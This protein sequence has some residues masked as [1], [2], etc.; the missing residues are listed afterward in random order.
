MAVV[1][2][3]GR[4][5][6]NVARNM[7]AEAKAPTDFGRSLEALNVQWR[8]ANGNFIRAD[9]LLVRVADKFKGMEDGAGKT[10][11][12]MKIFGE[13][14]GPRLVS[15]LNAGSDG[16]RQM[17]DE[18]KA[19]GI[20]FDLEAGQAAERFNDNMDRI[21]KAVGSFGTQVTTRILPALETLSKRMLEFATNSEIGK[22]AADAVAFV[23]KGLATVVT[24]TIGKLDQIAIV[25]K[26]TFQI[27]GAGARLNF[28]QAGNLFSQM[29]MELAASQKAAAETIKGIWGELAQAQLTQAAEFQEL[30]AAPIVRSTQAMTAAQREYNT[31]VSEGASIAASFRTPYEEM[32]VQ[33]DKLAELF[34]AGAIDADTLGKAN[35]KAAFSMANAYA[36]AAGDI[37][38]T[39][40]GV[41]SESKGFAI[42]QALINTAQGVTRTLAQYGAT[43]WGGAAAGA[44]LT[45]GMAQVAAI[46]KTTKSS[47][48]G[49]SS[50]AG[51]S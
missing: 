32:I 18:A 15:L 45:A 35:T 7:Q 43:P 8:D 37:A 26:R 2:E 40:A 44:A 38:G 30:V 42:A 12:A 17:T 39:L 5:F 28:T 6:R 23:F 9:D 29:G 31:A 27:I 36:N 24:E 21:G 33:Q 19:L 11:L 51:A 46:R 25:A 48:S 49:G 34:R 10:A 22:A 47:S 20:T 14:M 4:A 50:A 1:E 13:E 3:L 41:F 16:I